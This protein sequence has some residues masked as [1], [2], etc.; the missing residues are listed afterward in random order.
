MLFFMV[1]E[2]VS[3]GVGRSAVL[4]AAQA[5][6]DAATAAL[7]RLGEQPPQLAIVFGSSWYDQAMLLQGVRGVV[8]ELPLIGQSTAMEIA[9]E[10]PVTHSCSVVLVSTESPCCGVGIGYDADERPREAGQ[11]AAYAA[12]KG[13]QSKMRSGFLLFGDGLHASARETL[14]GLQEVLGT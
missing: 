2:S 6:R 3:A 1:A 10:G 8:G 13:L 11:R 5:G 4:D 9:P 7:E 12:L 14:R